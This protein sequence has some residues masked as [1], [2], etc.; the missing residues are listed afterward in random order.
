MENFVTILLKHPAGPQFLGD[1]F[2][3]NLYKVL[4]TPFTW[5]LLLGLLIAFFLWKSGFSARR[6]AVKESK[7]LENEVRDLQKH[8]NTQLKINASGNQ[9]LQ[10][11]LDTL[12]T[13]NETLRVNNASLQQKPGRAEQRLLHIYETAIRT[14]REQAPGF[15]PAWEKALRIAEAEVEASDT[16]LAKLVRRVMP[17]LTNSQVSGVNGQ[18]IAISSS[19]SYGEA[20]AEGNESERS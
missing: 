9:N 17:G 13:Q 6:H 10:A 2:T 19:D 20:A 15:A 16:G 7:R 12:R 3:E 5:G 8:L 18:T 11:E 1:T 14:M 4:Q